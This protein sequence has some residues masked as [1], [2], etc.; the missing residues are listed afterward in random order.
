MSGEVSAF[1]ATI[2]LLDLMKQICYVPC[3]RYYLA[4]DLHVGSSW[5][6]TKTSQTLSQRLAVAFFDG[7]S[8]C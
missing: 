4:E 1:K 3:L 5:Q 2:D 7:T 6:V 8:L